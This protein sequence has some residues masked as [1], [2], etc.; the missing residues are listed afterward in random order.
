MK[1]LKYIFLL[2]IS[3]VYLNAEEMKVYYPEFPG[4][5]GN[6][7]SFYSLG[8]LD[9]DHIWTM[10]STSKNENLDEQKLY[11]SILDRNFNFIKSVLLFDSQS[12]EPLPFFYL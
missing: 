3:V 7:M 4:L 11:I 8:L 6:K 10:T 9:D 12:G 2:L 5:Q 1:T